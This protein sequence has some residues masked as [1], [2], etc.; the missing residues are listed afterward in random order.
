MTITFTTPPSSADGARHHLQAATGNVEAAERASSALRASLSGAAEYDKILLRAAA[1]AGKS[2][3]LVRMVTEALDQAGCARVAVTAFANKQIFPLAG[4]LGRTLGADQVCLFVAADRLPEVHPEVRARV[5]I[6]TTTAG[7][8]DTCAVVLG[9]SHKLGA[10]GEPGR[11]LDHL[12]CGGNGTLPFDVLFVDEAWQLPRHRY[13][14]VEGLAPISVGV[15]DVGQLPPIDPSQNPWRGDPGYNPYRAWPTAYADRETTCVVDLPAVWR[16]TPPQL[17]LWRAFYSDWDQL[18][19]VAAPGD[20]SVELPPL[21]GAPA[22]VWASVASGAPTLVEVDGLPAPEAADV[23]LPLLGV[24]EELLTPLLAG[25]FTTVT[26]RYDGTGAPLGEV[27]TKSAAPDGDPLIVILATR[28]QAVD[29]AADLVARLTEAYDLPPGVLVAST[30]DS[31]QGQTNALTVAIHPLSGAEQLD[32]FN[33]AFGRLAVTCTRATHGLLLLA[34]SGL[35][36]ML[37]RAPARPGTPLGEPGS[38]SLP[39]QTHQRI[40]AAFSRGALS[41]VDLTV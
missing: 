3:A 8:P 20:R 32:E 18:D 28:N 19:C 12:G 35:D 24:V 36:E 4:D 39:R 29:D 23:D 1:G 7:I 14:K 34:R 11:L 33:S 41:S 38:R 37:D 10:L 26:R 31:W 15:G 17:A 25:G 22:A 6:A 27:R 5:T 30:V 16:P 9:T 21:T 2:Y 40:L 13:S